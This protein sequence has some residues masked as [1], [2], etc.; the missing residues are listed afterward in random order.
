MSAL[1]R[2][3]ILWGVVLSATIEIGIM[4]GDHVAHAILG[5]LTI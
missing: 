5:A 4:M 3:P 1:S 2:R